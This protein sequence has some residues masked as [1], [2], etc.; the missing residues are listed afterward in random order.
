MKIGE[1]YYC[2]CCGAVTHDLLPCSS[3]GHTFLNLSIEVAPDLPGES[4][5]NPSNENQIKIQ[6]PGN[7]PGYNAGFCSETPSPEEL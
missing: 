6:L 5:Y 4:P 1:I 2:S 3:C 7:I